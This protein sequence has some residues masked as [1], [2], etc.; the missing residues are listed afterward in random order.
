MDPVK[1]YI[2]GREKADVICPSCGTTR[3]LIFADTVVSRNCEIE[4]VC[5][6]TIPVFFEKRRSV[7]RPVLLTGTCFS[8]SDP[9]GG[10]M[11]RISDVSKTGMRF[12]K[13][14]G[15]RLELNETIRLRLRAKHCN[16]VIKCTAL[17]K[18]IDGNNIG[19]K[20]LNVDF[21]TQ[22]IIDSCVR[23]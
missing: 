1:V 10:I 16:Y 23:Q 14:A 9:P 13:D 8:K 12:L 5:G 7:R 2:V 18:N 3:A 22:K 20:F 17:V 15:E 6:I 21:N 4:C 11:V 19:V